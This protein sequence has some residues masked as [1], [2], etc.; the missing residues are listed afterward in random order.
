MIGAHRIRF[1]Q[2]SGRRGAGDRFWR[3]L[4]RQ[5]GL[6][7]GLRFYFGFRLRLRFRLGFGFRFWL[8]LGRRELDS[9]A[10]GQRRRERRRDLGRHRRRGCGWSLGRR[11]SPGRSRR[12]CRS[13]GWRCGPAGSS[14]TVT[15]NGFGGAGGGG[16][17]NASN[18]PATLRCASADKPATAVCWLKVGRMIAAAL[19]VSWIR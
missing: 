2:S 12:G 15:G 8:R 16:T 19:R 7:L 11:R 3:R 18:K 13:G 5:E 9:S 1:R 6:W 14:V 17:A 10:G 4:G